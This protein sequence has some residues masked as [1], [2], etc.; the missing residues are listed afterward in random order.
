MPRVANVSDFVDPRAQLA[1]EFKL[2]NKMEQVTQMMTELAESRKQVEHELSTSGWFA[3]RSARQRI[4]AIDVDVRKLMI[5]IQLLQDGWDIDLAV[6]RERDK[7][8]FRDALR[9][10][11]GDDAIV[12]ASKQG[13]SEY[14]GEG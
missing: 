1:H 5:I 4:D 9:Q 3:R 8:R 10:Q 14:F 2:T 6:L 7:V 11:V 12:A 13:L